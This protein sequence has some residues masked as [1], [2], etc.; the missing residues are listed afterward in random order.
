MIATLTLG[1]QDQRSFGERLRDREAC[2]L[3]ELFDTW[4]E[5]VHGYVRR[6]VGDEAAVEDLT[7]DIFLHVYRALPTYDPERDLRPWLFTIASNKVRDHWRSRPRQE[8]RREASIEEG[9]AEN[10]PSRGDAPDA[11]L[12]RRELSEA[13]RAAID[14]LP[15]NL[16]ETVRLRTYDGLS[17]EAISDRLGRN[18]VAVRKRY[19]RGLAALRETV[20]GTYRT[21]LLGG[22]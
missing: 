4:F 16:R 12:E 7:Q 11:G 3:E 5:R 17:F 22:A 8:A 20:E 9:A 6:V 1:P 13:V 19:S 2:A 18:V 21:H 10:L 15:A 14:R